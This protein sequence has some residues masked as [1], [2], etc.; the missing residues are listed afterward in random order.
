MQ[1]TLEAELAGMR[2]IVDDVAAQLSGMPEAAGSLRGVSRTL[3]R[4][5]KSWS[6]I[7]PYLVWDSAAILAVLKEV[8]PNL[9]VEVQREIEH[10]ASAGGAVVVGAVPDVAVVNDLDERARALL[11]R[12]TNLLPPDSPGASGPRTRI[13]AC[14]LEGLGRRPW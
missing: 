4:V 9:P 2:R 11:G 1:P 13:T 8:A 14:L 3:Q 5:E 10:L 12:V 6:K 7:L